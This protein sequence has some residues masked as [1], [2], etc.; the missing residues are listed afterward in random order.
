MEMTETAELIKVISYQAIVFDI[1]ITLPVCHFVG[2][3]LL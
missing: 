2:P 1:V 3:Y